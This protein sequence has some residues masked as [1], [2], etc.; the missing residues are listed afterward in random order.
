MTTASAPDARRYLPWVV[1]IV[2]FMETLDTTIVN[3][4]VPSMAQSL[5]GTIAYEAREPGML[6][7]LSFTAAA[8]LEQAAQ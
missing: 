8:P 1:A 5:G 4:A 3:T 6:A 7:R 2:L